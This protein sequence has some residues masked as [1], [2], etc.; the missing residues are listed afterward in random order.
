MLNS[1]G[2]ERVGIVMCENQRKRLSE[3]WLSPRQ[4]EWHNSSRK[5][6]LLL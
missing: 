6:T 5:A 2:I 4:K 1:L 3:M